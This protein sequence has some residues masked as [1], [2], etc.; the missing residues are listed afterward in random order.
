VNNWKNHAS[1]F[2]RIQKFS[3]TSTI[4]KYNKNVTLHV[5]FGAPLILGLICAP[6]F[7]RFPQFTLIKRANQRRAKSPIKEK[8]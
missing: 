6:F 4:E 3:L 7:T 8:S 1:S 5:N 2:L